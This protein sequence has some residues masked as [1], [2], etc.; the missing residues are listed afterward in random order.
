MCELSGKLIAWIDGELDAGE[1]AQ[2][3]RHLATCPDCR[4]CV[5]EFRRVSGAFTQYCGAVGAAQETSAALRLAPALCAVAAV[6]AGLIALVLAVPRA[7]LAPP[8][9]PPAAT[10]TVSVASASSVATNP[11]ARTTPIAATPPAVHRDT[12]RAK[13][14]DDQ[15]RAAAT[16]TAAISQPCRSTSC[17]A[18]PTNAP[19][20]SSLE[21]DAAIQIAIPA[22]AM[23]PPGAVPDGVSFVA[24]VS[25]GADG[26]IAQLRLLPRLIRFEKGAN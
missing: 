9:M 16:T 11:Q 2:T 17:G 10:P 15:G 3:E 26:A 22:D 19:P 20:P 23:F 24:D 6:A 12:H 14:R 21:D 5:T 13:G 18:P 4:N 1:A 25:L 7:R 8:A